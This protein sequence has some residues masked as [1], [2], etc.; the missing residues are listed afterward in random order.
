MKFCFD[1]VIEYLSYILF[2]ITYYAFLSSVSDW[3]W[4]SHKLVRWQYKINTWNP[5]LVITNVVIYLDYINFKKASL[6]LIIL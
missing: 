4:L 6:A 3:G 2:L 5:I 1:I